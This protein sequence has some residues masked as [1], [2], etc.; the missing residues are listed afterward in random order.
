MQHLHLGAKFSIDSKVIHVQD[1]VARGSIPLAKELALAGK[2]SQAETTAAQSGEVSKD[3][4]KSAT[5]YMSSEIATKVLLRTATEADAADITA[6]INDGAAAIGAAGGGIL[7]MPGHYVVTNSSSGYDSWDNRVAIWIRYNNVRLVGNGVGASRITLAAGSDAHVIKIGQRVGAGIIAVTGCGV[8]GL[9]IDGNRLNQALPA[10]ATNH[11]D[12]VNVSDACHRTVLRDLFIHD[13]VYYGI[14]FQ[15]SIFY[16]CEVSN[17]I[18]EGTGA[19]GIDCKDDTNGSTGNAIYRI[20]VRNFG[21]VSGT[22]TG[23]SAID[24]RSGWTAEKIDVEGFDGAGAEV[25][26]RLQNGTPGASP[27]QPTRVRNFRVLGNRKLNSVGVRVISRYCAL[28]DGYVKSMADGYSLSNPDLRFRD[29]IAENNSVGFRLWQDRAAGDEADTAG[30]S[31]LIARSNTQAGI[32]YDSVDEVTVQGAD[33]RGNGIGHDIRPGCSNIHIIGG[34]CSGNARNISEAA[35]V[36]NVYVRDVSGFRTREKLT[37]T[38]T[39]DTAGT[40]SITINH[41]LSV[42]PKI[43]DVSLTLQRITDV[44]DWS[45]GFLWVTGTTDTA[46]VIQYRV[47]T[48]S[49]T[50]GAIAKVLATISAKDA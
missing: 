12:G 21:L 24:L 26:I 15:R 17:I 23:Q 29:L 3:V 38:M 47:L 36:S 25:G 9:E 30:M 43:E 50:V 20:A 49:A 16:D 46:I 42:T 11:W 39:I 13:C 14:G 5:D 2:V 10:E 41:T 18:I 8:C 45:L 31:G 4:L 35:G 48:A 19:D 44:G 33:V 40:R 1:G 6:A 27:V 22:L 28:S 7:H 34:S 37:G 32:I